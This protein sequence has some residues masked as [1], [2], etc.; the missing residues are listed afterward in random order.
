MHVV[1]TDAQDQQAER[2]GV[3]VGKVC[4]TTAAVLNMVVVEL[5]GDLF[6]ELKEYVGRTC[7]WI[8]E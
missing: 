2:V 4:G 1:E 5:K 6:G 7:G 8:E 3:R